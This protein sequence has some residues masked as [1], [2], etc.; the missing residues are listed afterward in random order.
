[1]DERE[2]LTS[3]RGLIKEGAN[4]EALIA[5]GER[6]TE[7]EEER[8]QHPV[9]LIPKRWCPVEWTT[10]DGVS[11]VLVVD[12]S[13]TAPLYTVYCVTRGR[14]PEMLSNIYNIESFARQSYLDMCYAATM[15]KED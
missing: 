2:F 12:T 9:F 6:L 5:I 14:E 11:I 3:L 13:L 7:M 15:L 1:M 8:L 10:V 4:A